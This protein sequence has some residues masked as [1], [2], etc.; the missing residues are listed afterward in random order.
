MLKN[1]NTKRSIG[2]FTKMTPRKWILL[3]HTSLTGQ[4]A[5]SFSRLLPG[6]A[7]GRLAAAQ[8]QQGNDTSQT[9]PRHPLRTKLTRLHGTP[10]V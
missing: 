2:K 1:S 4:E 5:C 3:D 8:Q 6:T 7:S 10:F 9:P